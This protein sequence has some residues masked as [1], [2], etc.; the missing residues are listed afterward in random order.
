MEQ[1]FEKFLEEFSLFYQI[2]FARTVKSSNY[3]PL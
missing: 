3:N 1:V 2:S